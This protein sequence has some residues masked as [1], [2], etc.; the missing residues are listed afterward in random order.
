M[1]S[2]TESSSDSSSSETSS[3]E[4]RSSSV[5]SEH[6]ITLLPEP[7]PSLNASNNVELVE[8][9][10]AESIDFGQV[11][12]IEEDAMV[13][14][15]PFFQPADSSSESDEESAAPE[16]VEE[17]EIIEEALPPV[18]APVKSKKEMRK[19]GKRPK[20]GVRCPFLSIHPESCSHSTLAACNTAPQAGF[21]GNQLELRLLDGVERDFILSAAS[22]RLVLP[23]MGL[24]LPLLQFLT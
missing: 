17:V 19:S 1:S 2:A 12:T 20:G 21:R 6:A 22:F 7:L 5:A 3:S 9:S 11:V 16:V 10:D 8:S 15:V 14:G 18:I 4:S 13:S 24:I 23:T